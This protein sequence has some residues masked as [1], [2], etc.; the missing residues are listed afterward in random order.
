MCLWQNSVKCKN[1]YNTKKY[2][3]GFNFLKKHIL[4]I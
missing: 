1:V 3:L 2:V 4:I